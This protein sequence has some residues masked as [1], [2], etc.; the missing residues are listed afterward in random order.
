MKLTQ[1]VLKSI[2][3]YMNWCYNE[4]NLID[5]I[6]ITRNIL[7]LHLESINNLTLGGNPLFSI[8]SL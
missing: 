5:K 2:L 8:L 1:I 4:G 3:V 7:S 6:G